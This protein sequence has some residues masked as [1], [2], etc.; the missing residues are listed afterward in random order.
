MLPIPLSTPKEIAACG[1]IGAKIGFSALATSGVCPPTMIIPQLDLYN[2]VEDA[3]EAA[4]LIPDATLVRLS[5][6]A[7][8]AMA[9]DASPQVAEVLRPSPG[10]IARLLRRRRFLTGGQGQAHFLMWPCS[11]L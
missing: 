11:C 4:A 10:G 6:N 7:R 5:G 8:R 9:A 2:P 3:I 1:R